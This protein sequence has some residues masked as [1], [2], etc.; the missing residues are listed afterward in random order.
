MFQWVPG[1]IRD[2][3][4]KHLKKSIDVLI[5]LLGRDFSPSEEKERTTAKQGMSLY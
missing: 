3:E 2:T 4:I 5:T 1:F